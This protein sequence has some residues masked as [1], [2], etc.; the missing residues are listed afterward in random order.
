M[1]KTSDFE[2]ADYDAYLELMEQENIGYMPFANAVSYGGNG[3]VKTYVYDR[4]TTDI[5]TECE[6]YDGLY[7]DFIK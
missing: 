3:I 4:K 1:V 5:E 7:L 2:Y 6:E